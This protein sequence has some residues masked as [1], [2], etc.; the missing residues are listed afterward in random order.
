[1]KP[2]ILEIPHLWKPPD[3]SE[4]PSWLSQGFMTEKAAQ[5]ALDALNKG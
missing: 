5:D 2:T 3:G 4:Q 1:M